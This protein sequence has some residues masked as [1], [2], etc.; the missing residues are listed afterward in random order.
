MDSKTRDFDA[1]V[2]RVD[3][4][5]GHI[6][7]LARLLKHLMENQGTQHK[8]AAPEVISAL[9]HMTP[10][11]HVALQMIVSGCSNRDIAGQLGITEN[12]AKVHVRSI[13]NKLG[14]RTRAQIV[15]KVGPALNTMD[16]E[17]YLAASAGLPLDW[18]ETYRLQKD[19]PCK[20][21]YM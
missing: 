3:K 1:L 8:A 15:A 9:Y 12:T 11:Q 6:D 21:L 17:D 18:S 14:A 16:P 2:V 7:D 13:A 5:A 19:D 20:S 4:L 10:K